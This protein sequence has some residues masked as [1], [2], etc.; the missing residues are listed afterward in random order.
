MDVQR[1]FRRFNA[2]YFGGRLP[3][4]RVIQSDLYGG[5]GLCRMK[6]REIHLSPILQGS[7]LR[8]SLLHE[9]AHAATNG[10]HGALWQKEMRRLI[11][12]GAP[13]KEE[14]RAYLMN[15]DSQ[16]QLVGELEDAG[17]EIGDRS[18]WRSVRQN[19]GY[20]LN[21]LDKNGNVESRAAQ[22]LLKKFK[23]AF[24]AG[25][26]MSEYIKNNTRKLIA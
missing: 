14:L 25:V 5:D 21:L 4:Y 1:L 19:F 7:S 15:T 24:F 22:R 26:K 17:F 23:R 8:T 20:S 12:L 18:R 16:H 10:G 3:N 9:M 6:Q 11:R 13:L 2:K